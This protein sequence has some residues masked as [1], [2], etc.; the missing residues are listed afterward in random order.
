[1]KLVV[2]GAQWGDEGKGKIVDFLA[3][4]A[5]IVLRYSGGA[6]AGHTVVIQG[7]TFKLHLVPSG[8]ITPGK[9][10]VLGIGMVVDLEKLFEELDG[11]EEKGIF[12][13]PIITLTSFAAKSAA[14]SVSSAL[15]AVGGVAAALG[16]A[17]IA[18]RR[19]RRTA[20]GEESEA[21]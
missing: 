8:V 13:G 7:Q 17:A 12:R 4:G 2:I 11:L 21:E 15:P 18:A 16:A 14:G 9:L 3:E 20:E 1:M 10:A 5:D 6:N 19:R